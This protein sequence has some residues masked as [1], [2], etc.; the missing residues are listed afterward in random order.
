MRTATIK[1][2]SIREEKKKMKIGMTVELARACGALSETGSV[3]LPAGTRATLIGMR[4]HHAKVTLGVGGQ[5][6]YLATEYL[7]H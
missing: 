6:V 3:D 1:S 7:K 4:G 5:V 2:P